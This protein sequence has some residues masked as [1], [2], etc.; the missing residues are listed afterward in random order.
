[1]RS[2]LGDGASELFQRS[3]KA[4]KSSRRV[5]TIDAAHFVG[6]AACAERAA[7][8][9]P[10]AKSAGTMLKYIAMVLPGP[11]KAVV[12]SVGKGVSAVAPGP[13][14]SGWNGASTDA[15]MQQIYESVH[16]VPH[17][18]YDDPAREQH[19]NEMVDWQSDGGNEFARM[20]GC[21]K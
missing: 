17:V 12:G 9:E 3:L 6:E 19:Y 5:A 13:A 21:G 11:A 8:H 15:L 18:P 16:P 1:V 2:T 14:G 10:F 20:A 4:D 7:A